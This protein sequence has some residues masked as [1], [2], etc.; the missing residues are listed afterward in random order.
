MDVFEAFP[1]DIISE[2]YEL[3]E[4]NY[5]MEEGTEFTNG[6]LCDVIIEEENT[7]EHDRSTSAN[8]EYTDMLIYARPEQMPTL[9]AAKLTNSY[10]WHN[11]VNDFYYEIITALLGKNQETGE[12]EHIEFKVRQTEVIN[13]K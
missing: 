3:G 9:V 11:T 1:N 2:Q 5:A 13:G 4:V 8:E 12:V 7:A 10:M 6:Q